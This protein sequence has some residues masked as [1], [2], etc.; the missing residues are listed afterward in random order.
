MR[1]LS[2]AV[3]PADE[4]QAGVGLG[5]F[6]VQVEEM[7]AAG[8]TDDE[9][10]TATVTIKDRDGGV[11]GVTS[12]PVTN[13]MARFHHVVIDATGEV[14]LEISVDGARPLITKTI[15]VHS[16]PG[17]DSR[18]SLVSKGAE[19]QGGD[20]DSLGSIA[21]ADGRYSAF[22]SDSDN[23]VQGDENSSSD[24]FFFDKEK[25]KAEAIS[26]NDTG[27]LGNGASTNGVMSSCA[28]YLAY[29]SD[30]TNLVP[31]DT[32]GVTDIYFRDRHTNHTK[33]ISI[34]EK[35]VE[36][37]APSL[38][39]SI[40][41]CGAFV[42]FTSAATTLSSADTHGVT[43]IYIKDQAFGGLRLV[44]LF[45]GKPGEY[46]SADP[47]LSPN[48]DEIAFQTSIKNLEAD[49]RESTMQLVLTDLKTGEIVLVSRTPQNKPA[50][51][52]SGEPAIS[53]GGRYV[54]FSSDATD[55]T[56][57]Q[58]THGGAEVFLY[59]RETSTVTQVSTTTI[60]R[61]PD[62]PSMHPSISDNGRYVA[63]ESAATN[64]V[65]GDTNRSN[66]MFVLDRE[67]SLIERTTVD[68]DGNELEGDCIAGRISNDGRFVTFQSA[69][70]AVLPEQDLEGY[71]TYMGC[72]PFELL[73]GEDTP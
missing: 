39:P 27:E 11:S 65:P 62:G 72:N 5:H 28:R 59:D 58:N 73:E 57:T 45:N 61:A 63:F 8:V 18:P 7:E 55:M 3:E 29:E 71:Q 23:F 6:A 22:A 46:A 49:T 19:G 38:Q 40:S 54:V 67:S 17:I 70:E 41:G 25:G 30:A 42:A 43:Q 4:A 15:T 31:G 68:A 44:S 36:P 66:D 14:E 35:G 12:V 53:R 64:L 48:A 2:F 10:K 52:N 69:S 16:N 20:G 60:G 24:I 47:A 37:N 13:G 34:T 56:D 51:G 9:P 26:V 50:N 32:N 21:N 1:A 33:R